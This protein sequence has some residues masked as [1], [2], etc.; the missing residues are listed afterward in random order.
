MPEK[1]TPLASQV[2]RRIIQEMLAVKPD[3]IVAITVDEGSVPEQTDAFFAACLEAGAKPLVLSFHQA[4]CN[5]QA[6]MPDW[7]SAALEAALKTAD[8]WL[9]TNAV[10]LLYSDLWEAVMRDNRKLRYN[11]LAGASTASL[12]RVFC[13]YD[14][15]RM[16][17]ILEA[18]AARAAKAETVR[19]TSANGTDVRYDM[20]RRHLIDFD[21]GDFSTK[22][23]G[24]APGYINIVPKSG[25]M[26]GRIRFDAIMHA[27]LS[28]GGHVEFEMDA[29]RIV[30]FHG[31]EA[32][33][34]ADHIAG[35]GE[36]NM[37]KISHNMIGVA[38]GVRALSWEIVEDERIWGG[39]DFG[40][41][42][43][44]ALDMPPLGQ[45][46]SSHF[47]GVVT[48]V[49]LWFD[50]TPVIRDGEFVLPEIAGE[51]LAL[52]GTETV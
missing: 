7:P 13:N 46:A 19:I 4:R 1:T 10:V 35:F 31:P 47:D 17:H 21:S 5:G 25:S 27:D 16:G 18:L 20:D 36:E 33:I 6:G 48:R 30:T 3:E 32:K 43:T 51:A 40:F 12:N 37:Y 38:P 34:L 9:E 28:R 23:F 41:G 8:V 39:V 50:D 22:H 15:A 49:S 52:L 45:P 26:R 14:I 42:H 29:G 44:S 11:V 24:T 2:A